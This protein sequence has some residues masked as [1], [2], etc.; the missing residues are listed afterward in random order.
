MLAVN[1]IFRIFLVLIIFASANWT[2]S[3]ASFGAH[4]F[5]TSL[6]RIDYNSGE[7]LVEISIQ[8]FTHDL[9]PLLEQRAG[10]RVDLE[11][12]L[13][14]D[15]LIF[16]YLNET[17]VLSDRKG[18]IRNLKWV[19]KE[20]DVD[21]IWIYVETPSKE[22]PE[23]FNLQNTIFF[24]SFQE[25]TNLVICRYEGKKTDLMFKVGDKTKEILTSKPKEDN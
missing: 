12:T 4:R 23:N 8:L 18:E 13:D 5:H 2:I 20:L 17:F 10:R 11:K 3:A 1:K 16:D 6:T 21:S 25:Q 7:Q 9:A 15:K 14:V 22:S 24:E 19:G